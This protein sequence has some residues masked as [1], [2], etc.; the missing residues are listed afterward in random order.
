METTGIASPFL[1]CWWC[2]SPTAPRRGRRERQPPST[3]THP[4]GSGSGRA[5]RSRNSP[6]PGRA[7]RAAAGAGRPRNPPGRVDPGAAGSPCRGIAGG[8]GS[9]G[10]AAAWRALR[11]ASAARRAAHEVGSGLRS[12]I[13]PLRRCRSRRSRRTRGSPALR[14]AAGTPPQARS[15]RRSRQISLRLRDRRPRARP[16][17]RRA[18]PRRV[19]RSPPGARREAASRSRSS[20]R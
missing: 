10:A 16:V 18:A 19:R 14:R 6:Q 8:R 17:P 4:P 9:T 15:G 13:C 12:P 7:R 2:F 5:H 3:S 20:R 11:R 1:G